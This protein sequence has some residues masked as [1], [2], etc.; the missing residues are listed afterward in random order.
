MLL[1]GLVGE[2]GETEI[3]ERYTTLFFLLLG[4]TLLHCCSSHS[5]PTALFFARTWSSW[6][7]VQVSLSY[8]HYVLKAEL[9]G[10]VN[11]QGLCC[12]LSLRIFFLILIYCSAFLISACSFDCFGKSYSLLCLT[13]FNPLF[14]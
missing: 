7:Y 10:G 13:H 1:G 8:L 9:V 11:P 6:V 5:T 12:L 3:P 4:M 14:S 2:E